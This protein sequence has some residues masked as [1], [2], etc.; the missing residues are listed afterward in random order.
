M[1][2]LVDCLSTKFQKGMCWWKQLAL[3]YVMQEANVTFES[4][5]LLAM[6]ML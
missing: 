1:V 4:F 3:L 2:F 6:C 5:T